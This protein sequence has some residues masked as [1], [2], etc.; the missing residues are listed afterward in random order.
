MNIFLDKP[1]PFPI[2]N[3]NGVNSGFGPSTGL[4]Y[5]KDSP[6]LPKLRLG[7]GVF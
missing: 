1:Y 7:G 3:D 5:T 2:T 6:T 4:I